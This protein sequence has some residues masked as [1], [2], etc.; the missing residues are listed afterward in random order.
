MHSL[1][2]P[3]TEFKASPGQLSKTLQTERKAW[4]CLLCVKAWVSSPALREMED[5]LFTKT[6]Y[7]II[8]VGVC[9]QACLQEDGF[10]YLPPLQFKP[11][12]RLESS[13]F[14]ACTVI[15]HHLPPL[16]PCSPELA[17]LR[18]YRQGEALPTLNHSVWVSTLLS[19]IIVRNT[20]REY[21][22]SHVPQTLHWVLWGEVSTTL[23][24][25]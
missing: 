7:H 8:T 1:P 2:G 14:N 17:H 23:L 13:L 22:F 25:G 4:A 20:E 24:S 12:A 16:L 6:H 3:Q 9:P 11:C 21:R 5:K 10:R 18:A 19:D 15:R